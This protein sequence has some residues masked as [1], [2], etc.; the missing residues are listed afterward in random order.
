MGCWLITPRIP[1]KGLAIFRLAY[2]SSKR[3]CDALQSVKWSVLRLEPQLF[4][5]FEGGK[6]GLGAPP[7]SMR[8]INFRQ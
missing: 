2:G 5:V 1:T 4:G 6:A 8:H 3:I 7:L